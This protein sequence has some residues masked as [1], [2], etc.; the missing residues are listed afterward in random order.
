MDHYNEQVKENIVQNNVQK[1]GDFELNKIYC[2]DCLEGLKKLPDKSVDLVVTDP[3]YGIL[4]GNRTIGGENL[5]K[6]REYKAITWD[7]KPSQE[8]FNEILRVS[9]NQIIF[10][11][12][13]FTDMLPQSKGWEV[14]PKEKDCVLSVMLRK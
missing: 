14:W 1:I 12:E 6:V 9:K 13:Y 8:L 11:A 3:P 7:N 2:M 5:C 4:N 10:G